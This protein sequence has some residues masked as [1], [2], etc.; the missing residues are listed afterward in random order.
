MA[1]IVL[2]SLLQGLAS[3]FPVYS[4]TCLNTALATYGGRVWLPPQQSRDVDELRRGVGNRPLGMLA[5]LKA[6]WSPIDPTAGGD[7]AGRLAL[8]QYDDEL[9]G[10]L[11]MYWRIPAKIN[12]PI[13]DNLFELR[14]EVVD[15]ALGAKV[16]QAWQ[17]GLE[18]RLKALLVAAA[19]GEDQLVFAEV[20]CAYWLR[21]RLS[22]EAGIELVWP[23]MAG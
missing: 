22:D 13:T 8:A 5:D 7:D 17:Q 20:E 2:V 19:S 11:D 10:N 15:E 4:Q 14:R 16:T 3:R 18:T 21:C 23:E 6:G 9:L 12:S 1:R